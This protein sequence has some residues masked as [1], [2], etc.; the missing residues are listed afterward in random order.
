MQDPAQRRRT[1]SPPAMSASKASTS[2]SPSGSDS[3]TQH[4]P[5]IVLV[6]AKTPAV[7][8]VQAIIDVLK[9]QVASERT[10]YVKR[11]MEQNTQK[12]VDV[13]KDLFKMSAERNA[14]INGTVQAVDLLAKRQK[15]AIDMQNG[16]STSSGDSDGNSSQ[17][18]GYAS[19]AI[20]LGSSIAVKNAVRPIKL[21]E[22][23]RL[24]PYTTWIFLDRNQR[25]TEDQSVVGRRR[26]Y[27][28][29]NGGEALICS[30][31]E[32]DAVDEEDEKKEFTE[33]EDY[34]L[35]MTVKQF[36]FSDVILDVLA[37]CFS[38]KPDEIKVCAGHARWVL[39]PT[40]VGLV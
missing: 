14:K 22:V 34:I 8:E 13:T 12:L 37:Q 1:A 10:V 30:D 17:E 33:S 32:E 4:H 20:L 24:P 23:K 2:S 40:L 36:G 9:E 6:D 15:D 11:R 5:S 35:R 31:S 7:L 3:L 28:D 29:Q 19:S 27:Y 39:S 21:P 26:I 25:M 16:I 18:D 38:R